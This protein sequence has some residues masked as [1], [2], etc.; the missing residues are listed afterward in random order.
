MIGKIQLIL[1]AAAVAALSM[2]GAIAGETGGGKAANGHGSQASKGK[3]IVFTEPVVITVPTSP[4]KDCTHCP[5][6]PS[7]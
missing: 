2:N 1:A 4:K 3:K 5:A 7:R 6:P